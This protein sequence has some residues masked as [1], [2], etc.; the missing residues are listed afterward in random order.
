MADSG[1]ISFRRIHVVGQFGASDN[2][3][4]SLI[5][6]FTRKGDEQSQKIKGDDSNWIRTRVSPGRHPP[7]T[8]SYQ[9][10]SRGYDLMR[11]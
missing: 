7:G 4:C 2:M 11:G 9:S 6:R 5:E 10:P 8:C 3:N 1:N